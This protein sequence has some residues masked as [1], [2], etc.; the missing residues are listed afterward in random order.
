[1]SKSLNFS[2]LLVLYPYFC[3]EIAPILLPYT[4]QLGHFSKLHRN[5]TVKIQSLLV[6]IVS[7]FFF[8]S[9]LQSI[10]ISAFHIML[11]SV[12][13]TRLKSQQ[14][15]NILTVSCEAMAASALARFS[16][17][18]SNMVYCETVSPMIVI[19]LY[20]ANRCHFRVIAALNFLRFMIFS[21]YVLGGG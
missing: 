17:I 7:V 13:S 10:T 20:S 12:C 19:I 11:L 8:H 15:L 6:N 14:M 1:M 3:T 21:S 4:F 16:T 2:D 5:C 9:T 18:A